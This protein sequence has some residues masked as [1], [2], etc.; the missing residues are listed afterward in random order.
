V[1]AGTVITTDVA[2]QCKDAGANF[3][4]APGFNPAIVEFAGKEG[5]A[6]LPGGLTP[7]EVVAAWMAGADFVKVFPCSEVGG[8]RYIK[9]LKTALPQIP[10]IAARGVKQ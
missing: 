4:T 2:R 5:L 3:L 9:R 1:G 7:T 8:E 6:V 10:L